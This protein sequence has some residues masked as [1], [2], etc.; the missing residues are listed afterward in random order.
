MHPQKAIIIGGG[1]AGLT[2]AYELLKR[3][4]IKPVV[5]EMSGRLGGISGTVNYKGNR[6]DIGGHRFFSR[7]DRVINWWLNLLPLQGKAGA[8]TVI[9]YHGIENLVKQTNQDIDPYKTDKVMLIRPRKSRIYYRRKFFDYPISLSKTTIANLGFLR[10]TLMALSYLKSHLFPIHDEQNLEQFLINRF[11]RKLYLTFFKSYTEKVWGIPCEQMSADWG[12]QRIKGLSMSKVVWHA[13]PKLFGRQKTLTQKTETSLIEW[14]LYPKYG[15]GQLWETCGEEII[16]MGGDI[17]MNFK[18]NR[19]INQGDRVVEVAGI[20]HERGQSISFTGDYFFSTM[21]VRNLIQGME[22]EVPEPVRSIGDGLVYRDFITIGL[23]LSE[24]D[25]HEQTEN[26]RKSLSDN[27]IYIQES[28]VRIGRLQI[29]NN[30]SPWMVADPATVWLGLEYFCREGDELWKL[31]DQELAEFGAR[32]IEQIG[33]I[34]RSKILDYTVIRIPKAYPAYCGSY[35]QFE[36]LREWLDRFENLFLIGRNG[37]HR[38]NNQDHSMLTAM[39]AV[40]NILAGRIDKTNIWV[41][42]T[43][44]DYHESSTFN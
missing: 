8:D 15:P 34:D 31:N 39:L 12:V 14:F 3:T 22:A 2:A 21:P 35:H 40:D 10:A 16:K 37:M 5:L 23:L 6:I 30:W 1:P 4:Q 36:Q 20:D 7:S 28:E 11:G 32:E 33:I 25:I 26:G 27:W 44:P 42:N 9:K 17:I 13:L 41:L 38:Y 43:E 18:V 29:F 24:L 19:I